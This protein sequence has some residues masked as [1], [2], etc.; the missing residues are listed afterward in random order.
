[1]RDLFIALGAAP[2]KVHVLRWAVDHTFFAPAPEAGG[3]PF[4]LALGEARGRDYPLLLAAVAGLPIELR[5]LPG[6]YT[7]G[8]EKRPAAFAGT[9][10]NVAI[11]PHASMHQLRDLYA[12]ARFVVLPLLDEVFPAGVT[13]TLEAMCMARAVIAVRSRGL[14]DYVVDGETC[15]LVEPG[16][17]AGMRAAIHRLASDPALARRLGENGRALVET[18][19]NQQR[20]VE[21]LAALVSDWAAA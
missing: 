15:L 16:D 4:A 21:Q 17:V 9:P 2:E 7:G 5:V 12:Q 13:T 19:L 11:L 6:G 8:R 3:A 20:Y 18:G 10:D 1:M 14:S